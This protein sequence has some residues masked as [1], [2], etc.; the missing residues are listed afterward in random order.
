MFPERK[1]NS[2]VRSQAC[3]MKRKASCS[4]RATCELSGALWFYA[5]GSAVLSSLATR[6]EL[7]RYMNVHTVFAETV[8]FMIKK[9]CELCGALSFSCGETCVFHATARC[10][11]CTANSNRDGAPVVVHTLKETRNFGCALTLGSRKLSFS[12]PETRSKRSA[13]HAF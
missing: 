10:D 7:K 4:R 1:G 5:S 9:T 8:V 2:I 12:I 6:S 13:G 3:A 11:L